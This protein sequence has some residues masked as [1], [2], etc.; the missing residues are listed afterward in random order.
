MA[1]TPASAGRHVTPAAAAEIGRLD[2]CGQAAL[3]RAGGVSP[4]ELTEAAIVRIEALDPTLNAVSHRAFDQALAA[5]ER[6]D[7]RG[8]DSP[9]YG[10]PWLAK[11][12]L[13]Y[14]GMPTRFGSR[15]FAD[16]PP[17]TAAYPFAQ[18]LDA[19]GLVAVG[20]SAAPEFA[21]LPATEPLLYGPTRNP[22]DLALSAGGSSGGA[23]A[24]VAA[25]L[26]PVA[27]AADGGGSIR[28]PASC[29]GVFGLKPSRL[30]HVRAR[31]HHWAEDLLV[32]DTLLSRSVRDVHWTTWLTAQTPG[33]RP[34]RRDLQPLRIAVCLT[35]LEGAQ[36]D[37]E[38]AEA[39]RA[40]GRLCEGLGHHVADI[41]PPVDGPCVA[42]AFKVFWGYLAA[43]AAALAEPR[44]AGRPREA[45]LEPWT[46]GLADWSRS[47]TGAD[48]EAAFTDAAHAT[49]ALERAFADWDVI[50]SPVVRTPPP[51]IGALAPTQPFEILRARMFDYVAYTQLHNL[52]G[53]PAFSAPLAWSSA[54]API[55]VMAAAARGQDERLLQLAYQLEEAAPWADRWPGW[56]VGGEAGH[57]NLGG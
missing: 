11:E 9:L 5:S 25:G 12:G 47:L 42:Q 46:I 28:I 18:R 41:A 15:L 21:L 16:A 3:A 27:H 30:Q 33:E 1:R 44:Q 7:P 24:A 54:G 48:L 49:V 57:A 13:D 29:C 10:V 19:A 32:S 45:V 6:L 43:E 34:V 51:P 31:G 50:L 37:P 8:V 36:P 35:S 56:S 53:A 26:T 2:A 17:A 4:R 38:V 52:T 40:A 39:V 22:W 23:A 20:K 55:G 14:P